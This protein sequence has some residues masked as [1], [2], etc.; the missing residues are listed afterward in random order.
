MSSKN[1][2]PIKIS[3]NNTILNVFRIFSKTGERIFDIL[4]NT[5]GTVFEAQLRGLFLV[6]LEKLKKDRKCKPC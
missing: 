1:F 5:T 3:L 2:H 6:S 4:K